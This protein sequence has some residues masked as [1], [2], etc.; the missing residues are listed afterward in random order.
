MMDQST[1]DRLR[2]AAAEAS[3]MGHGLDVSFHR[4]GHHSRRPAAG[5]IGWERYSWSTP[6]RRCAKC[7]RKVTSGVVR[8]GMAGREAE[9]EFA[10]LCSS[11]YSEVMSLDTPEGF[12]R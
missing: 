11:C 5:V 4:A 7:S 3:E 2:Q 8:V 1:E 12:E 10:V 9:L 6:K